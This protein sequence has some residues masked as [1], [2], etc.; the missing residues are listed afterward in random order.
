MYRRR[1]APSVRFLLKMLESCDNRAGGEQREGS[2]LPPEAAALLASMGIYLFRFAVLR[3]ILGEDDQRPSTR[4]LGR[5]ILPGMLGR[6]RLA[7]FPFV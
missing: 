1:P 6:Y 3:E 2:P 5:T 4:D 7:A